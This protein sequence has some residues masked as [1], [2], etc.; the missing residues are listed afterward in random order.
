MFEEKNYLTVSELNHAIQQVLQMG[1]PQSLWV[2]GEIQGYNRSRTKKHVFF[3]LCEKDTLTKDVVAKTSLVIFAN[4]KPYL[5]KVLTENGNPFELKDDIEVKFL[6][7]VD[8]YPPHGVIRLVVESIDPAYTLGKIAAERQRLIALLKKNGTLDKNKQLAFP[9]LPMRI[10]LV[11][12]YDSAAYNDFL[13]E[14][15]LS[16]FGFQ[17]FYRNALMQGKGAEEDICC[18]LEEFYQVGC[19]ID[20]I[21]ITRG[22]GSIADLSCFDSQK[23]AETIARSPLPVLSGIGHEIDLTVTDLAVHTSQKTPTAVAQFLIMKV[24]G[25][26]ASLEER[27]SVLLSLVE[28]G[29]RRQSDRLRKIAFDLQ[30]RVRVF[31][32]DHVREVVRIEEL[33][34]REPAKLVQKASVELDLQKGSFLNS[35]K[36]FLQQEKQRIEHCRRFID[37]S[38]PENIF[39]RGF[40]VTRSREGALIRSVGDVKKGQPIC[41]YLY[42]GKVESTVDHL[43]Q[44]G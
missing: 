32:K 15:R 41:T 36:K 23:I 31:L 24:E 25:A 20:V 42:N 8:F 4:R 30:E 7:K 14:L 39:R 21:V 1:F 19:G 6:C 35:L 13:S 29:V 22:G 37:M 27:G 34:Q 43:E 5:E 17:V 18:A 38:H 33:I 11:T 40:S 10:G 26:L 3:D 28:D 44:G 16:G 2:C 12:S 9:D